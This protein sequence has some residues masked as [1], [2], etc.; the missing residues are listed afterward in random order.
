MK[1]KLIFDC[2]Q[3]HTILQYLA[4]TT[5]FFLLE[6]FKAEPLYNPLTLLHS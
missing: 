4:I 5:A 1:G 6:L 3:I 2:Y